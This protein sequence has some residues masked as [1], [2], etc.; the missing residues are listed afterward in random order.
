MSRSTISAAARGLGL[1]AL[2][3][4]CPAPAG[5]QD[6][7]LELRL[8]LAGLP[9]SLTL[10]RFPA[11]VAANNGLDAIWQLLIDRDGN[12]F[13]GFQDGSGLGIDS[14]V[15][16]TTAPQSAGCTPHSV[17]TEGSLTVAL[18]LW[19]EG[20]QGFVATALVPQLEVDVAAAALRV[21]I[22]GGGE[23]A[24]LGPGATI[25]AASAHAYEDGLD[26]GTEL[27]GDGT[28]GVSPGAS[29][30][31]PAG[32]VGECAG[33]CSPAA[34]WYPLIDLVG[35]SAQT[36]Q[37]AALPLK[38]GWALDGLPANFDLCR[39]PAAF[40]ASADSD[41][42][43]YAAIDIDGDPG[44]GEGLGGGY[45]AL[46]VVNTTPQAPGC[47]TH[48]EAAAQALSAVVGRFVAGAPGMLEAVE[49][50]A[51]RTEGDL[52]AVDV[53]RTAAALAGFGPQSRIQLSAHALYQAGSAIYTQDTMAPLAIGMTGLDAGH[54]VAVCQA[55]CSPFVDWYAQVD[56][57]GGLVEDAVHVFGN[58]FEAP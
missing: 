54:D 51:V 17:A 18:G 32:D 6:E 14:L 38:I 24:P 21:S 12:P 30:A 9:A 19:N 13:T 43:W 27:A 50:L 2:L 1:C 48:A 15:Q 45:E 29:V 28:A 52:L 55:P 49:S 36:T 26:A 20:S 25:R 57:V 37:P 46:V 5:A 8:D 4:L 58:G 7:S 10:C 11:A 56:L 31:D 47:A 3:G 16:I 39:Y 35:F 33:S 34:P 42:R 22:P 40:Q 53:D 44:T 41:S 23:F